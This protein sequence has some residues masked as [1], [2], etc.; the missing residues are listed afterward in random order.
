MKECRKCKETKSFDE[1][2]QNTRN[3]KTGLSAWCKVC[4]KQNKKEHYQA[5]R[6]QYIQNG[7]KGREWFLEYK[8]GLKCERCG[9]SH[10][11]ALDFHHI[12]PSTK[13][14]RMSD[15][16]PCMK[17]REKMFEEIKKC[18]VL[19]ANCHRI[20]HAIHIKT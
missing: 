9:F 6:D 14:F 7:L 11:A 13:S 1:F 8:K 16:N 10:P 20:E 18:E 5:N 3:K 15:I 12:D 19:C 4:Q 2:H 17:N